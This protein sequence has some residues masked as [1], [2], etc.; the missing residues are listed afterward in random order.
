MFRKNIFTILFLFLGLF[1][2]AQNAPS[3]TQIVNQIETFYVDA[4][5]QLVMQHMRKSA[6][7][8]I[9]LDIRSSEETQQGKISNAIEMDFKSKDFDTQLET[10][11][12]DK[13]YVVYCYNGSLSSKA[14]AKMK[15]LG[16]KQVL[17]L[18]DGYKSWPSAE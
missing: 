8:V 4:D 3:S 5:A 18:K 13:R 6:N 17:N 7:D 15:N 16:F 14:A 1:T 9:F 2:Y 10:L 12:K 11:D